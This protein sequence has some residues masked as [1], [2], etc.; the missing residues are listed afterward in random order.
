MGVEVMDFLLTDLAFDG[1][2]DDQT[3]VMHIN[4]PLGGSWTPI[5]TVGVVFLCEKQGE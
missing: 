3:S 1:R 2:A 4:T 5:N